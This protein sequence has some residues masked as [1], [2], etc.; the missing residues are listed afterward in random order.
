MVRTIL[1]ILLAV[2]VVA[3]VLGFVG[4]VGAFT[5]SILVIFWL[6]IALLILGSLVAALGGGSEA[7]R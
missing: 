1:G 4:L 2:I 5:P 6:G 7:L 3:G